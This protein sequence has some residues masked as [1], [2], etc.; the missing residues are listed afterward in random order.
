VVKGINVLS[1][2]L[3]EADAETLRQMIDRF[4][5]QYPTKGVVVLGSVRDGRPMLVAGITE[6]LISQG[7]NAIDLIKFMAAPLGGSGGGKPTLAQAGGKDATML[8]NV[9]EGVEGWVDKHLTK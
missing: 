3:T 1:V 6:D 7:L 9:L 5:Q 2:K 4:R 8:S